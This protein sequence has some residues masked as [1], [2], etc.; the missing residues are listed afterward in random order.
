M[1][2]EVEVLSNRIGG[3][4]VVTVRKEVRKKVEEKFKWAVVLKLCNGNPFNAPAMVTALKTAWKIKKDLSY[5]E[6]IHNKVVVKLRS[7]EEQLR[8]LEGGPWTFMGWAV[9]VEKW[10]NGSAPTVYNSRSIRMWV[11]VHNVPSELREGSTSTPQEIASLV[12]KVIMDE[13][14]DGNKDASRRKWDRFRVDIDVDKPILHGV[15]LAEE[16]RDPVWIDFKYERLPTLCF[17]CGRLTHESNKCDFGSEHQPG[18]RRFGK[19]LRADYHG[20]G[21]ASP[22]AME[23]LNLS[24]QGEI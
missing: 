20:L 13:K 14:Q 23:I 21:T 12:G 19:W 15:V 7:E 3:E 2:S 18:K 17:S 5:Q 4:L 8:I 22:M 1:E 10:R 16:D 9:I 6:M 11:Q 24:D